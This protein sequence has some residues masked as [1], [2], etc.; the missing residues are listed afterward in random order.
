MPVPLRRHI[1]G[2]HTSRMTLGDDVNLEE[3][4]LSKDQLSGADIK[5]SLALVERPERSRVVCV[6]VCAGGCPWVS[7]RVSCVSSSGS[8]RADHQSAQQSVSSFVLGA[9]VVRR[10]RIAN[11]YDRRSRC[12][13]LS[14]P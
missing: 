9:S 13:G 12:H 1:F 8:G 5:A 3:F 11:L 14:S 4:V 7:V 6:S 2:I 10:Q